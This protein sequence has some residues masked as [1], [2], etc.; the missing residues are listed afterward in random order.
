MTGLERTLAG[1]VGIMSSS[2]N[3]SPRL[4]QAI[5]KPSPDV[6]EF[7]SVITGQRMPRR[8]HLA[9]LFADQ[10]IMAN[11]SEHVLGKRWIDQSTERTAYEQHLLC[12]IEYWYRMGYD[13]IRVGG[14]VSFAGNKTAADDTAELSRGKRGWAKS[15]S[16]IL[17]GPEDLER[18]PWPKVKDEDLWMYE[19]VGR[20]LPEGMGIMA[21]PAS[22]L[23][24]IITSG[25]GY[26][27]LC[28]LICDQPGL[29][30]AFVQRIGNILF[31][32]YSRLVQIPGVVGF[33]QGDDMG[34]KT[35]TMVSPEFLRKEILPW[36]K[37]VAQLAH[38]HGKI[39][40]LHC[41]GQIES[42]MED[43]IDDTRIDG[44]HSFE[45]EII[46]VEGF[47][48][49]YGRRVG[50][51]G[52]VPVDLLARGSQEQVRQRVR[53]ILEVCMP[54]GRYAL[55]S[56]NS[57]ANYTKP[58]NFLAMLDEGLAFGDK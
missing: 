49:K 10:P 27:T 56:G 32:A 35:A 2:F 17:A 1:D 23:F 3:L 14:G 13:Y 34:Y 21:C 29:V 33:F 24:E 30:S 58:E 53:D 41:C 19:F 15:S 38:D 18:Y 44:K 22:G 46:P 45:D 57:V 26:E 25:V 52:G 51:L 40:L 6:E 8:V 48:H 28:Y 55:G 54:I 47:A 16:E 4:R 50:V 31:D 5:R 20:H 39:Y 37:K 43:L 9:E 7:V 11:I 12:Q 42:I 36:H